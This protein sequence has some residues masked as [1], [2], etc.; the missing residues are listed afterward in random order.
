MT[1]VAAVQQHGSQRQEYTPRQS[2][3]GPTSSQSRPPNYTPGS[4]SQTSGHE[5]PSQN[6]I[7]AVA[8]PRADLSSAQV[9]NSKRTRPQASE[10]AMQ[11]SASSSAQDTNAPA[12][13]VI[14]R[15]ASIQARPTSAP[16]GVGEA[17]DEGGTQRNGRRPNLLLQRAKSDIGIR[18]EDTDSQSDETQD[19]GARH[20]FED[21]YA[22]EE[23]VSQ[24]A[25]VSLLFSPA[26]TSFCSVFQVKF[27]A[28]DAFRTSHKKLVA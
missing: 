22:S 14:S 13:S 3:N 11:P 17:S 5:V 28:P 15:R 6:E 9:Q 1:A 18:V 20:G 2:S 24:L 26:W 25:N 23:Y 7:Y 19:W 8:D 4:I 27:I 12:L 10:T 21:H 16:N